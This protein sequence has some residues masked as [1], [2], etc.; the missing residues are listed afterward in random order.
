MAWIEGTTGT[1]LG[2]RVGPAGEGTSLVFREEREERA[3]ALVEGPKS[4]LP[5]RG[6]SLPPSLPATSRSSFTST[7]LAIIIRVLWLRGLTESRT[8]RTCLEMFHGTFSA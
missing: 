5:Y 8:A 7:L 3:E 2:S 4:H 1:S 6:P